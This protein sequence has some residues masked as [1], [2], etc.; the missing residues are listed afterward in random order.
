VKQYQER[1]KAR[2]RNEDKL[3]Y[4]SL[5]Y[6]SSVHVPATEQKILSFLSIVQG[7]GDEVY[8]EGHI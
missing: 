1:E 6:N 7:Q 3:S 2:G 8:G 5:V 4:R